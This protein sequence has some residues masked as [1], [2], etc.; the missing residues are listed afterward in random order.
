[1][2]RLYTG[3]LWLVFPFA[4]LRLWWR[5]RRQPAYRRHWRERLG[6]LAPDWPQGPPCTWLHA[7]S[8]G[9][10]RAAVPLIEALLAEQPGTP[11]LVTTTTPTGRE[12]LRAQFGDRVRCAWLPW[13]LPGFVARFVA[14]VRPARVLVMETELWPNLFHQ[15]AVRNIPL[16]LVNARLSERALRRY[17]RLRPL[18]R[19]ALAGVAGI[20]AQTPEDARRLVVLGAPAGRVRAVGN[21]KFDAP[22]PAGSGPRQE[23]LLGLV[24][25]RPAWVAASTHPGEELP[26]IE[27]QRALRARFQPDA[28]LLL[29]PRHPERAGPLVLACRQAGLDA[30]LLSQCLA[31]RGAAPEVLLIDRL[32]WLAAC[33][34]V[35]PVAFLG[36]S[37]IEHGGHNPLE[38]VQ[39]GACVLTGRH[40]HNFADVYRRLDAAGAMEWIA[41]PERLPARLGE[42]L[43]APGLRAQR[44]EAAR[45]VLDQNRG[46]CGR[47]MAMLAAGAA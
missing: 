47:I 13:D 32:G 15:L 27:A 6:W 29:A 46:A 21:L 33:Y 45:R 38:A 40:V 12:A 28:L 23:Q 16:W 11:L 26:L 39:A 3:L 31:T 19:G 24:G 30:A 1:M 44:L 17:A 36:G 2:R 22:L 41:Q 14:R 10:L 25:A 8:V 5:G 37:L 35:A 7:V 9:E 34:G 43:A 18:M 20:A 4:L 42:L